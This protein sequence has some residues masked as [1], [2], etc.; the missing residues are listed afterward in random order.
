MIRCAFFLCF[1][2]LIASATAG[3]SQGMQGCY[4]LPVPVVNP[5]VP[6]RPAPPI[7][8]TVQVDVPVPC[9]PVYCGP[10]MP[11]PP[12]P[13]A[14]PVCAPPPC[15]TRP[16]QVRVDVVVRPENTQPCVP[17]RFCCENPPVFEPFFCKAAGMIQSLIA[18]PL[19]IGERFMGHPVPAALPPATPIPCWRMCAPINPACVQPPPAT[20]CM[21]V[22]PPVGC[23]PAG[24][25]AKVRPSCVPISARTYPLNYPYPK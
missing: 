14:P 3:F 8:R 6:Q 10:P 17:Q 1:F 23:A 5:R 15:P 11:C 16:V 2:L 24:P 22:C 19:C 13:C 20:R 9:A 12:N 25:P 7:T 18:A 21:P 4:P